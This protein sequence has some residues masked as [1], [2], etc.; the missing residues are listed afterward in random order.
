[1]CVPVLTLPVVTSRTSSN[2]P[3]AFSLAPQIPLLLTTV[4]VYK[5]VH[6]R[7]YLLTYYFPVKIMVKHS[8]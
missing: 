4:R 8:G 3:S 2:E 6:L 5:F 1:M 7:T